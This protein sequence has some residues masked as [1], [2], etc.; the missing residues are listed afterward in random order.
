MM[1]VLFV[2]QTTIR[3]SMSQIQLYH[4]GGALKSTDILSYQDIN[5]P[6]Y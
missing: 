4:R 2:A 3:W 6:E 5:K 1:I